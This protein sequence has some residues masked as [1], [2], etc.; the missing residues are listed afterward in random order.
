MVLVKGY[1]INA[2]LKNMIFSYVIF[3]CHDYQPFI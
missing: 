3:Q 2:K 1:M